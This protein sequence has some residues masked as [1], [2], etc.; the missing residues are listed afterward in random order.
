[1]KRLMFLIAGVFLLV[2]PPSQAYQLLS[3]DTLGKWLTNGPP[4]DFLLIDV[5]E[6]S[7]MTSVIAT[8]NCRPYH[9]A[10]NSHSFDSSKAQLPKDKAIICYCASGGRS[11]LAAAAL[12]AAGFSSAYSLSGGFSGWHGSTEPFSYVKP[13]S[14]LPAP[15]MTRSS[16]LSLYAPRRL[17][18]PVTLIEENGVLICNLQLSGP[19]AIFLFSPDG[20]CVEKIRDPFSNKT[21]Y[22]PSACLRSGHYMVRLET[23]SFIT[24]PLLIKLF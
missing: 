16:V 2:P 1:M 14:D 19:H 11:G 13:V 21:W 18:D 20:R 9:L 4:F 15:S 8:E 22:R 5:R 23:Q 24:G 12:D 10:W 17:C 7:E 6:T 3:A